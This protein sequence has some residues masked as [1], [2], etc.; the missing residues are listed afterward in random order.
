MHESVF[1]SENLDICLSLVIE[2][3]DFLGIFSVYLIDVAELIKLLTLL[4]CKPY[5]HI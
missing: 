3:H 5:I 4:K 1:F 2:L